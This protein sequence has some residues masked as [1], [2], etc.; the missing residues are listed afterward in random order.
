M[1]LT[2]QQEDD[3][4]ADPFGFSEYCKDHLIEFKIVTENELGIK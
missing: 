2:P 3:F 4:L 1:A